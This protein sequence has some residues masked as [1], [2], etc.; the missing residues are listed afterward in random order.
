M[1]T[2]T[3]MI[4]MV[5]SALVLLTTAAICLLIFVLHRR[6]GCAWSRVALIAGVATLFA[7]GFCSAMS[8]Y[9]GM[10]RFGSFT[11][12]F[13]MPLF[14]AWGYVARLRGLLALTLAF[15]FLGM[16]ISERGK[17]RVARRRKT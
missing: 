11:F 9:F 6:T 5:Y 12:P 16:A 10:S 13:I 8:M 15:S 14:H 1:D 2:I 17:R 4:G 3:T 7:E